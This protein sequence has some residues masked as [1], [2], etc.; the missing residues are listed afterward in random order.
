MTSISQRATRATAAFSLRK[1]VA[2]LCVFLI[3]LVGS[4]HLLHTHPAGDDATNP[5]CSLCAVAHL[6]PL[7]AALHV[8]PAVSEQIFPLPRFLSSSA[9]QRYFAPGFYVRP[10][11]ASTP[12]A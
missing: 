8:I 9:P 1:L 7:P 11:P 10:P 5:A 3:L 4:A 12:H 6:A 2:L